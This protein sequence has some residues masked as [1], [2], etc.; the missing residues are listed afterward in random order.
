MGDEFFGWDPL[1]LGVIDI[2][3]IGGEGWFFAMSSTVQ[4]G[5]R[6]DWSSAKMTSGLER[7]L[8]FHLKNCLQNFFRKKIKKKK[9]SKKYLPRDLSIGG[10][11]ATDTEAGWGTGGHDLAH[12][13]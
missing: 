7:R 8:K 1:A 2:S 13:S 5:W 10:I 12:A 4:K 3:N 11:R 6:D 9:K